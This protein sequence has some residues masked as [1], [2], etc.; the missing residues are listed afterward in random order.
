MVQTQEDFD[1]LKSSNM[2]R[3]EVLREILSALG[4][5]CDLREAPALTPLYLLLASEVS[6]SYSA[7]WLF[8]LA[9]VLI[10]IMIFHFCIDFEVRNPLTDVRVSLTCFGV[11]R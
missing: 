11:R 3:Y 5:S 6:T 1:L 9:L 4:V 2:R 8:P 10:F 7:L